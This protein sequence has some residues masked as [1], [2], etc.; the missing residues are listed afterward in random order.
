MVIAAIT[1]FAVN[2]AFLTLEHFD[3]VQR[4][5][6]AA[7]VYSR[8]DLNAAENFGSLFGFLLWAA[9]SLVCFLIGTRQ[10]SPFY[11]H[12]RALA[13][14]FLLPAIDEITGVHV[15]ISLFLRRVLN[16]SG[17]F[18]YKLGWAIPAAIL[19]IL[20]I[21]IFYRFLAS[22]P[23]ATRYLSLA[24]LAVFAF[25]AV[26][27]EVVSNYFG[28]PCGYTCWSYEVSSN[29][30]EA[31]QLIGQMILLHSLLACATTLEDGPVSLRI[32]R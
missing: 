11:K 4:I 24:G 6:F 26:G 25:G 32:S 9:S 17:F 27:L 19:V 18:V 20:A 23:A 30:E 13:I 21:P 31:V 29:V 12:W 16:A 15:I 7:V 22:L 10:D 28:G 14:A 3:L 1:L 5:G 8:F 2:A